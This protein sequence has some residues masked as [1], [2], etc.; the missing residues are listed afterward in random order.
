MSLCSPE[1]DVLQLLKEEQNLSCLIK[2]EEQ[3]KVFRGWDFCYNFHDNVISF[4]TK[5]AVQIS[6]PTA[7][8]CEWWMN[9]Q[10]A[11]SLR[12]SQS[13]FQTKLRLNI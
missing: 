10:H 8:L 13:P 12:N 9:I 5:E 4:W 3:G 2:E 6:H 1:A 11:G 7:G